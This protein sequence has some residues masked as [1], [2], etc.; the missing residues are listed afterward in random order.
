MAHQASEASVLDR[1]L[2]LAPLQPAGS[3]ILSRLVLTVPRAVGAYKRPFPSQFTAT[4]LSFLGG[5][6]PRVRARSR[7][8]LT[9]CLALARF[10]NNWTRSLLLN[11]NVLHSS[12]RSTELYSTNLDLLTGKFKV[13]KNTPSHTV[14][15]RQQSLHFFKCHINILIHDQIPRPRLQE[16]TTNIQYGLR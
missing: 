6:R 5:G 15:P 16:T 7:T 8:L 11:C 1:G 10:Q 2:H 4:V 3:E 9:E 14:I 12:N 13:S